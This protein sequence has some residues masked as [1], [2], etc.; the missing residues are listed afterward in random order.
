MLPLTA[1][2]WV[3]APPNTPTSPGREDRVAADPEHATQSATIKEFATFASLVAAGPPLIERVRFCMLLY[4]RLI[5]NPCNPAGRARE[6]SKD[7][8]WDVLLRPCGRLLLPHVLRCPPGT[9]KVF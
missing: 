9:H 2:A 1:A 5:A 4:A 7:V 8:P 3:P 6:G